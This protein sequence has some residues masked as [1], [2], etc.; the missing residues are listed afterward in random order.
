MILSNHL[1]CHVLLLLSIFPSIRVFFY[2]SSL[3]VA[4]VLEL[5]LKHQSFQWKFSVD[6]FK[7]DWFDLLVVQGTLKSLLQHHTLEASILWWSAFFMVQLSLSWKK[8]WWKSLPHKRIKKKIKRNEDLEISESENGSCSVVSRFHNY[9]DHGIL[10]ARILEWITFPF[11]GVSSQPRDQTQVSFIAGWFFTS[12][13]TR[14][15][16]EYQSG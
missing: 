15:T 9:K 6:F 13:A 5:Q 4:K 16:Q 10:Q 8:E 11:S 7:I 1:I 14:E 3:Q 12:W 2:E